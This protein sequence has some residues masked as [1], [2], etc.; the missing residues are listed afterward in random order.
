M[1]LSETYEVEFQVPV[2]ILTEKI[3]LQRQL[4]H[5][6]PQIV[7]LLKLHESQRCKKN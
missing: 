3:G 5:Q 4:R 6:V 2:S 7:P 1:E